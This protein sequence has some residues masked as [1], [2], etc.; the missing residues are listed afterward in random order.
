MSRGFLSM[1]C[2]FLSM[3]WLHCDCSSLLS[4]LVVCWLTGFTHRGCLWWCVGLQVLHTVAVSTKKI[5]VTRKEENLPAGS[6]DC[7]DTAI[8][9]LEVCWIIVYARWLSQHSGRKEGNVLFN[10]ALNTFYFMVIW[11]RTYGKE[12]LR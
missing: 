1:S 2:G 8:S 3:S 5:Q 10:D 11:C 7:S 9:W 4:W 12:P 6:F